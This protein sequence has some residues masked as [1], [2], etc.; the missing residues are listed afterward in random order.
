MPLRPSL[1]WLLIFVPLS[2]VAVFVIRQP[3]LVFLTACLAIIPLAGLIGRS[4]DSLATHAGPRVGGLLNATF[5]NL[6]ELVV[7][8]L[9]VSH[10]EFQVV[11]ASLMGSIIGNIALVL[12]ASWFAGGLRRKELEFSARSAAMQISSL[13]LAVLALMMPALFVALNPDTGI[14]RLEISLVV[15]TVLIVL[16]VSA[17]VFSYVTHAHLFRTPVAREQA[18]WPLGQALLVLAASAVVVG[19]ESEFLTNSIEPTVAALGISRIFIGMFVVAIIGN[20]AEHASAVMFALRDKMDTANEIAF[21]SATQI[22]LFVAPLLVFVSV[23]IGRPMDFVFSPFEVAAVGLPTIIV[24][25]AVM[26]GRTNWLEG[27][28]LLGAYVILAVSFF[29]VR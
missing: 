7:A 4:T 9:L 27:L 26:D 8:V 12:G 15:A 21:G 10:G 6:T 29:F 22:A 19:V 2:L 18:E 20:A 13:L 17:L 14:E 23:A 16:Y 1:N 11:K 24:A 25:V 28:Q 3:T 5:G